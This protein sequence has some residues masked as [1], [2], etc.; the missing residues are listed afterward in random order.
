MTEPQQQAFTRSVGSE[1]QA[2][3]TVRDIEGQ[4][5]DQRAAARFESDSLEPQ[6]K[7]GCGTHAMRSLT[8]SRRRKAAA[9]TPTESRTRMKPRASASGRLP[10]LVS[11]AIVVVIM[12]V[13]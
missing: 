5:L 12:R 3:R 13:T 4:R 11:S 2:T 1:Q 9:F 7:D 8:V 10:L 6:G